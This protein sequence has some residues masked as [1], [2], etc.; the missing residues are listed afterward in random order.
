[1]FRRKTLAA[2]ALMLVLSTL[3]SACGGDT[4][5]ATPIAAPTATTAAAI[6]DATATTGTAMP[7][8]NLS[9]TVKFWTAYNT[10]SPEMD[11]LNNTIIPAFQKLHPN[12][13]VEA[14]ALPYDD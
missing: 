1:M 7:E 14:Q 2:P 10:V 8:D 12:V 3:L 6:V 11:T 13:K 9:G 5:T 4:P